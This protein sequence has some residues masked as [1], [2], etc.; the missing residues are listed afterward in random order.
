[1]IGHDLRKAPARSGF[2]LGA[3]GG[4]ALQKKPQVV[5]GERRSVFSKAYDGMASSAKEAA[6]SIAMT[7]TPTSA[8]S[9]SPISSP[10]VIPDI[11]SPPL[12]K[13]SC[14]QYM[15]LQVYIAIWMV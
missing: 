13:G 12:Q 10:M 8:P 3:G 5:T 6:L 7:K 9:G 2:S 14:Q 11:F 15:L 1:M 4:S